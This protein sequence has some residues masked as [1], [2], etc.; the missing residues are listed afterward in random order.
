MNRTMFVFFFR[1]YYQLMIF[2]TD[3]QLNFVELVNTYTRNQKLSGNKKMEKKEKNT[4]TLFFFTGTF[5][6][7][8]FFFSKQ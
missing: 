4:M 6:I 2:F 7:T 8:L 1:Q 3:P 5:N